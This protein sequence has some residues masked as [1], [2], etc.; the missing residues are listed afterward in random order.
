M[1]APDVD[2][3]L[4]DELGGSGQ[5]VLWETLTSPEVGALAT[6]RRAAVVPFGAVEQHGPHMPLCVD[7]MIADH[8]ARGVSALTG[9]PVV[10]PVTY[11]ISAS[12]GDFPGTLGVK[13]ETFLAVVDDLCDW[14]YRSGVRDFVLLNGHAWNNSALQ[15]AADK[16][17]TRH[18]DVRVR[19]LDYVDC[20]P[21]EEIDGR[22]THGRLLAHANYF[23]TSLMLWIA[24]ELVHLDRAVE[25]GDWPSFWDYR[26][27]QVSESGVWGRDVPRATAENG[28]R[29]ARQCIETMARAVA[30]GLREPFGRPAEV[31]A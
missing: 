12:H 27:D 20:Y 6:E 22:Y 30:A 7:W 25:D 24:P 15:V 10:H 9:V 3:A 19:A 16:L 29:E 17:R 5:P 23:E 2:P 11:G 13:A 1:R 21:P 28:E 4:A 18:D 14:L 31:G 26:E 8:V